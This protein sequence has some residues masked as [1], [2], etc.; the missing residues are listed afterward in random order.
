MELT[1]NLA[2]AIIAAGCYALLFR[3]LSIQETWHGRGPSHA[4]CVIALTCVL[5]ILFPVISLTDDLCEMQATLEEGTSSTLALRK[6]AVTHSSN[7]GLNLHQISFI[8][9]SWETT[10]RWATLGAMAAQQ[11]VG[12][13]S[14]WHLFTPSRAPPSLANS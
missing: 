3:R 9:A 14:N 4:Q 8:L 6:C 13:T 7:Q 5:A 2:W 1:L 12:S 10:G 11:I